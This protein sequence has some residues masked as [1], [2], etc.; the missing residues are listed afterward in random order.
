MVAF[1]CVLH[2]QIN[3]PRSEK[4]AQIGRSPLDQRGICEIA[5]L[6]VKY[7]QVSWA[8]GMHGFRENSYRTKVIFL[9]VLVIVL[10]GGGIFLFVPDRGIRNVHPVQVSAGAYHTCSLFSDHTLKC[11]GRNGNGQLGNENYKGALLPQSVPEITSAS[12]VSAGGFH[13]C[14]LLLNRKVSCWGTNDSGQIGDGP[15]SGRP[16]P[17]EISQIDNAIAISAGSR[18]TCAVFLGGTVRCWGG[19]QHGQLGTGAVPTSSSVPVKVPKITRARDVSAGGS[20]TCVLL[21]VGQV[22]CWGGNDN[23]QLGRGTF[24]RTGEPWMVLGLENVMAL[25]SGGDHSCALVS[26]GSIWCWGE[27]NDGQI[28]NEASGNSHSPVR[29]PGITDAVAVTTGAFHSCALRKEGELICWGRGVNGQL[30]ISEQSGEGELVPVPEL[31]TAVAVTAGAFHTC[32]LDK[33]GRIECWGANDSGQL[34]T[35][36]PRGHAPERGFVALLF[37]P[38]SAI[39]LG[40]N[41]ISCLKSKA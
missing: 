6:G 26:D 2:S 23:G 21:Q 4:S 1:F 34:G 17:K 27:N 3:I 8:I 13:T 18:H 10:T 9:G 33:A 29:V 11:W 40:A 28:G 37:R 7:L 38:R 12:V 39:D 41:R 22:A 15:F 30:G 35:G 31:N 25:S 14:V 36:G 5:S 19:N 20:H 32:V 16:H 24:S